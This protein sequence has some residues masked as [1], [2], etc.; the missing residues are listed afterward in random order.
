V[1]EYTVM[2]Y[3]VERMKGLFYKGGF[4]PE[5]QERALALGRVICRYAPHVLGVVEASDK[6][7]NIEFFVQNTDLCSRGYRIAKSERR[8]GRQDL[9]FLYR[10]PFELESLDDGYDFWDAWIQDI[11]HDGIKEVCEFERKPLEAV[12][13]V[14]GT[15]ARVLVILVAAKSKGVFQAKDVL[16]HQHLALANR[17]KLLAQ[18]MKIRARVDAVM[19]EDPALPVIV[20]GDMNDDPGLDSYERMLGAS[21]L[22]TIMGS[23]YAPDRILH[24]TLWHLMKTKRRRDLW[25]LEYPDLIVQNLEMNR[26]WI[27]HIFVSPNML[28]GRAGLAYVVDSG[29]V[30]EKDDDARAASDHFPVYCRVRC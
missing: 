18:A 21:S 23:V 20:M 29:D 28:D 15:E 12:F 2:T 27:D 22:E 1:G 11:D 4:H 24:N 30:A 19:D 8:R 13:R 6:L 10:E 14:A 7:G 3:N 26:A 16:D 5:K 25:T 9:A 17:K